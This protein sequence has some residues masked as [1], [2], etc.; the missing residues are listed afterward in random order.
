MDKRIISVNGSLRVLDDEF[1]NSGRLKNVF[2]SSL[3]SDFKV[4][5]SSEVLE[6]KLLIFKVVDEFLVRWVENRHSVCGSRL[7]DHKIVIQVPGR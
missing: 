3:Y 7:N 4:L 2:D 1:E 6:V 5:D